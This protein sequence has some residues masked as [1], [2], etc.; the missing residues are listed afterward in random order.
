[1][2]NLFKEIG[3]VIIVLIIGLLLGFY[4]MSSC[5][6]NTPNPKIEDKWVKTEILTPTNTVPSSLGSQTKA[7]T[8]TIKGWVTREVKVPIYVKVHDTLHHYIDSS[9][10]FTA[11]V[12]LD[13]ISDPHLDFYIYD[14]IYNN[15]V[16]TRKT[17]YLNKD[18]IVTIVHDSVTVPLPGKIKFKDGALIFGAGVA[19]GFVGAVI[20]LK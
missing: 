7:L 14:S 3:A 11:Q 9:K 8:E 16:V 4:F 1:M 6:R 2:T 15:Q 20:L 18:S 17:W 10:F 12:S 19:V 5:D 13:T